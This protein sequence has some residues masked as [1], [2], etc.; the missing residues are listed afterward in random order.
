V[1]RKY[2]CSL[3]I[4]SSKIA[5]CCA[6]LKG[7]RIID[8]T[9]DS[10]P[11]QGVK[12]GSIVDSIEFVDSASR[13]M[14]RLKDKSGISIRSVVA[15]ISGQDIITR[16]SSAVIPLSER[17]S[18][19]ITSADI[20]KVDGQ[21]CILGSSIDEEIIHSIP[22]GYTVDSK[23]DIVN[24]AGLYG[25]KLEVDMFLVCVRLPLMQT[26]VHAIG[27]AG[28]DVEE[29]FF[30][31]LASSEVVFRTAIRK[32]PDIL[33]DI[34]SDFTELLFFND[35]HIR[36]ILSLPFGGAGFTSVVADSLDI[37]LD[38]A[39]DIRISHGQIGDFSRIKED[40][41]VLVKKE[42]GYKP[43]R[44]RL[45]CEILTSKA[46]S[47]VSSIKESINKVCVLSEV[48]NFILL[49]RTIQQEGFL[50]LLEAELGVNVEYGRVH[51]P[52]IS[53]PAG[54]SRE[55]LTGRK[56][57]TYITALGLV[58]LSLYSQQK[59]MSSPLSSH[60][61]PLL[62]IIGKAKEIYQEYF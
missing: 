18:K 31:G 29:L 43:I 56:N 55:L 52:K 21:A 15:G 58:Y 49:G 13:L 3:D 39:E 10:V 19:V 4:G 36:S 30:S 25:H 51:D 47:M 38:F 26:V 57:L 6:E 42:A 40:Q 46:K 48:N 22:F 54:K 61:N 45:L 9:C 37:P 20:E 53:I 5:G 27:Q 62:K 33:C 24:P 28:F 8:L 12:Y 60:P 11:V 1:A 50:E 35:G 59:K 17:G 7:D 23:T 34:G 14:K 2:V 44:Q 16:H 32:G 41:E